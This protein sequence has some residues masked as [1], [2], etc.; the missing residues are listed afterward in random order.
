MRNPQSL[1]YLLI[2]G[3]FAEK[4]CQLDSCN[5]LSMSFLA[6]NGFYSTGQR[7]S[8]KIQTAD[9]I[10]YSNNEL[11]IGVITIRL[12]QEPTEPTVRWNQ[13]KTSLFTSHT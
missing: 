1:T 8:M 6:H 9:S 10:F 11:Q 7:N 13:S 3:S 12:I 4:L 5:G 2:Y